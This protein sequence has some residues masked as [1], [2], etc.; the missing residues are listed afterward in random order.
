MRSDWLFPA[1]NECVF[2]IS[3][4]GQSE[5]EAYAEM[6][7][8]NNI[9]VVKEVCGSYGTIDY[10][11]T[12]KSARDVNLYVQPEDVGRARDMLERFENEQVDYHL[13]FSSRKPHK[14]YKSRMWYTFLI[15]ML[16]VFPVTLGIM[17][18]IRKIVA[19]F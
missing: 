4:K 3:I 1:V 11:T 19:R 13:S 10:L 12:E 8:K 14:V 7:T 6:F 17:A 5:A 18:I 9:P 2:L 16:I 15:C